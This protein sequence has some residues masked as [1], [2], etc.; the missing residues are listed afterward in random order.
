MFAPLHEDS[1]SE[2]ERSVVLTAPR[3]NWDDIIKHVG[4]DVWGIDSPHL[5]QYKIIK[6]LVAGASPLKRRALL[7]VKTGGGKS[8]VV[9]I[10][11]AILRGIH[12]VLVPLLALG[13]DQVWKGNSA[14]HPYS[15]TIRAIHLDE[16]KDPA[17]IEMVRSFLMNMTS[18]KTLIIVASPQSLLKKFPWNKLLLDCALKRNLVRGVYVDEYHQFAAFG[19]SFRPEFEESGKQFLSKLYHAR[20]I[21]MGYEFPSYLAMSAT[22]NARVIHDGQNQTKIFVH[23]DQ[24][25]WSPPVDFTR[26]EISISLDLIQPKQVTRAVFGSILKILTSNGSSKI[27]LYTN[28][29]LVS[30]SLQDK[31]EDYLD[32]N[33]FNGDVIL[34]NGGLEASE[35]F[36]AIKLFLGNLPSQ[37][38]L[39]RV[40]V[41]TAGAANC[42]IDDPL[43]YSV[44]RL[45]FPCSIL[46]LIQELGRAAR[47]LGASIDTDSFRLFINI[48][49]YA[50]ILIR[51]FRNCRTLVKEANKIS[52]AGTVA[53]AKRTTMIKKAQRI[54]DQDLRDIREVVYYLCLDFGCLHAR[55]EYAQCDPLM[56]DQFMFPPPCANA[57]YFC[58]NQHKKW[59][60]AVSFSGL[61]QYFISLIPFGK[62]LLSKAIDLLW[63]NKPL[64]HLVFKIKSVNKYNIEGLFLQ[65]LATGLLHLAVGT[66]AFPEITNTDDATKIP[67]S[68]YVWIAFEPHNGNPSY[69]LPHRW[70]G[71]NTV[72]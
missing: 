8:A 30:E 63:Q 35:K 20:P 17:T 3:H 9:Q 12:I 19:S 49:D 33:S 37:S 13:A 50:Y 36:F 59:F 72:S 10:T 6:T 57:C 4:K 38:I 48:H 62:I 22:M 66:D 69:N 42:G 47:R 53:I 41:F 31:L 44:H 43:I 70:H 5:Y 56:R 54:K 23:R 34:V 28:S 51:A 26:R 15:K 65:L 16:V 25:F 11:A 32:Q 24:F 60:R 1:E 45:G 55:L 67:D 68:L 58:T 29:K 71:I 46:D 52:G 2:D 18:D 40:G 39:P 21:P 14:R 7:C 61:R 27:I 64:L